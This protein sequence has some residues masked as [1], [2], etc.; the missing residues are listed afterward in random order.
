MT[1]AEITE[2]CQCW[3]QKLRLQDWDVSI[4]LVRQYEIP[5]CFGDC[6]Y[7]VQTKSAKIRLV[8]QDDVDPEAP[9]PELEHT[10]VHELLHL[11]FAPFWDDSR[12]VELEQAINL[13]AGALVNGD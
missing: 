10:L 3:Q 13:I 11:H 2:C 9:F 12:M 1:L 5:G 4:Q 6:T 7:A 8:V